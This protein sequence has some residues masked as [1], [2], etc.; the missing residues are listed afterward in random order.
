MAVPRYLLFSDTG[1]GISVDSL[2]PALDPFGEIRDSSL[3]SHEGTRL[4]YIG[5]QMVELHNGHLTLEG[6][7]GVR[8]F[9]H[10]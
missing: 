8:D 9:G 2:T 4:I 10:H 1:I 7:V 5:K 6:E 3:V